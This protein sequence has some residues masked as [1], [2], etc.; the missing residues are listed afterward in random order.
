MMSRWRLGL[1]LAVL[2]GVLL[3]TQGCAGCEDKT[4]ASSSEQL[5]KPQDDR[6]PMRRRVIPGLHHP[7]FPFHPADA[8]APVE[9]DAGRG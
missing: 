4:P 3:G 1:G 6:T 8:A 5:G 9:V 2:V 7:M